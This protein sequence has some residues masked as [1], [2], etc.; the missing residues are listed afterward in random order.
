MLLKIGFFFPMK[1]YTYVGFG[2]KYFSDFLLFHKHLHINNMISIEGDIGNSK[3]Y[4]FNKPL[5][6]INLIF[7]MSHDILPDLSI[8]SKFITWLDYD[9]LLNQNCLNDI[10]TMVSKSDSGS[11]LLVSYNSRPLKEAE[12]E[13]NFPKVSVKNRPITTL[14]NQLGENFIP[15]DVDTRGLSN[16]EKYSKLLRQIVINCIDS[17]LALLNQGASNKLLCKQIINFNYQDG[18]EMSTIGFV[19]IKDNE[20]SQLELCDFSQFDFFR[21]DENIYH[22]DVP[23]LT[24]KE[25]KA[26]TEYMPGDKKIVKNF[27]GIVA[28]TDISKFEKLYKYLP[29][30]SD[31]E[32]I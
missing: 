9:G 4:D 26:L 15:H 2:S 22:I 31:T 12:L 3:K 6:C 23:N 28:P 21:E 11:V 32:V 24:V 30:F 25:I 16:W 10:A 7:G 27:C 13:K 14:K 1:N 19:F 5:K 18:V 20:L 29:N 17:R 8:D